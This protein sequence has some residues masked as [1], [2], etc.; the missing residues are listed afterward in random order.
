MFVTS[1][2]T[3][4][5][6]A[7]KL[8]RDLLVRY[9][10]SPAPHK[11]RGVWMN[12][13]PSTWGERSRM[14][15]TVGTGR[16]DD[17]RKLGTLQA[18]LGV[19]QQLMQDP[20]NTLVDYNK[21]YETL[22]EIS[23]ISGFSDA[24]KFFYDPTSPDGTQFGQMKAQQGQQAQQ[25]AMAEQ[26]QQLEMQVAALNAQQT[27]A[28]AE[29]QKAQATLMNGQL[30]AEIDHLKNQHAAEL[31]ALKAQLQAIKDAK[32]SEFKV[33]KLKTDAALKLTD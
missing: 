23:D 27:V 13:N 19:Q 22:S 28:N 31:D 12:V 33:Q 30:K 2:E 3:G 9:Q 24:G 7:Y 5:R 18:I 25:Q 1:P 29:A 17:D 21:I 15:V 20:M 11:H 26:Q 4:I 10:D 32:E 6:P 8:I 16:S 14:M